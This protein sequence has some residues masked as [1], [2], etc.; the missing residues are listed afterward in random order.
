MACGLLSMLIVDVAVDSMLRSH[1][2]STDLPTQ[3]DTFVS[4]C[5][6]GSKGEERCYM[7]VAQNAQ[8]RHEP[9]EPFD[10]PLRT[11]QARGT[12]RSTPWT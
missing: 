4:V 5:Y 12:P 3:L 10:T 1:P 6:H 9:D 8:R 11:P 7:P 2:V